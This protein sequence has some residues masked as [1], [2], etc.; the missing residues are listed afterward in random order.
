ME[1]LAL[2]TVHGNTPAAT[3]AHN[4]IAVLDVAGAGNVPVAIGARRPLA[5]EVDL[6]AMVHGEDG[7]GG[8]APATVRRAPVA[9]PAAVQLV[10]V[11][12]AHPGE[13]TIVATGPLTNLALA[14]LLEPGLAQLVAGVVLM[15]GT[16]LHPGNVSP[17]AEANIWH[18]PEAADLVFGAGWPLVQVGLDVTMTTWLEGDDLARLAATTTERGRFPGPF[19]SIIWGSTTSATA[20]PAALCTTRVQPS[21]PCIPN[22]APICERPY[23]SS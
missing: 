1:I 10:E 15:G 16:V 8:A 11:A 12:T 23:P 3:A 17:L 20:D 13:C 9:T 7:L 19:S 21:W 22:W 4:A 14:L 6:S 18:D 2:G 5:Q